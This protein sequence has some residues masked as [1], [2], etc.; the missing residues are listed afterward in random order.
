MLIDVSLCYF[1][2]VLLDLDESI[3]TKNLG[4]PVIVVGCKVRLS[5]SFSIK[6]LNHFVSFSLLSLTHFLTLNS[7]SLYHFCFLSPLYFSLLLL[8]SL[9]FFSSLSHTLYFFSSSFLV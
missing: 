4:I 6:F 3:L 5:Y 1:V 8:L 7:L 9:R 2:Q